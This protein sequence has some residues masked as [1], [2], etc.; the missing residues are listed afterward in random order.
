MLLLLKNFSEKELND[1]KKFVSSPVYSSGRN[2]LPIIKEILKYNIS[3]SDKISSAELYSKIYPG[4]KFRD[5]TLKNRFSELFKLGEE[6]LIYKSIKE[7]KFERDKL[8]LN[9][10]IQ[11]NLEKFFESY[12]RKTF[13]EIDS[14]K[15]EDLKFANIQ[16]LQT[17]NLVYLNREQR[18]DKFYNSLYENS[19]YSVCTTLLSLFEFGLEFK[20]QEDY[21]NKK[22][23][24]NPVMGILKNIDFMKIIK[25]FNG[26]DFKIM[27]IVRMMYHLYKAY[28]KIENEEEYFEG[29]KI[30]NE[31]KESLSDTYKLKIYMTLIY[32]CIRKQNLGIIKFEYELFN[33]YNEKLGSGFY[34]DFSE[35]IYP[36]NNFR[37]YVFI[38][39]RVK[40]YEWV[41]N[42]IEKYS[43]LLPEYMKNNEINLSYA[44][45]TQARNNFK[46]SYCFLQKVKPNNYL[47]YLD[48]SVLKLVCFYE[49]KM[50]EEAFFEIDK[51]KHYLKNHN[52]IPKTHKTNISN[53][54]KIYLSLLKAVTQIEGN[55]LGLV[56]NEILKISVISRREWLLEK[57]ADVK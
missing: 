47:H 29:K 5:Q 48:N 11:N 40:Q 23:D 28:E 32:Y 41:E 14:L 6:F 22:Y 46:D 17:L 53:F 27:N 2:Y 52:E 45:L 12:Y 8:L 13:K 34:S 18:M 57:V 24:F 36:V 15:D 38:G 9:S 25:N 44:R 49:L 4:K 16:Y 54:L 56:K 50:F 10:F 30:F 31:I 19:I 42:F 55:N 43:Y 51:L 26:K 1:F 33:L 39:I 20:Q 21:M 35:K 3:D 7:N 37:D